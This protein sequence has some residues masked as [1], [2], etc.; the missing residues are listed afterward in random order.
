MAVILYIILHSISGTC[1]ILKNKEYNDIKA[2][3]PMTL[4]ISM[5]IYMPSE[6]QIW[7]RQH[8][9]IAFTRYVIALSV[10]LF[11]YSMTYD[12]NV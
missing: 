9:D 7:V 8:I 3:K 6:V 5:A 4:D 2:T 12:N 11:I 10:I 1:L